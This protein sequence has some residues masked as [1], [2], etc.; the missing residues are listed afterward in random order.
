MLGMPLLSKSHNASIKLRISIA[1]FSESMYKQIII[2]SRLLN[3]LL[4]NIQEK[5]IVASNS[6]SNRN[7]T[8]GAHALWVT[9]WF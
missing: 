4:D 7:I 2:E 9:V 3:E 6:L 8:V 1:I 5:Q